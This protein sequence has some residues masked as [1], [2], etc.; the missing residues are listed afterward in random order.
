MLSGSERERRRPWRPPP[1]AASE[2]RARGG[3]GAAGRPAFRGGTHPRG[4]CK[5]SA[6]T[7]VAL[8]L[9]KGNLRAMHP[10][11]AHHSQLH[12][13]LN[14]L[15]GT[16]AQRGQ[17]GVRSVAQQ[18]DAARTPHIL[19]QMKRSRLAAC[20]VA[21]L[22]AARAEP[23]CLGTMDTPLSTAN[24]PT[25]WS[26]LF[27]RTQQAPT[28]LGRRQLP[29]LPARDPVRLYHQRQLV[30]GV[31]VKVQLLCRAGASSA[32]HGLVGEQLEAGW[33]P[34]CGAHKSWLAS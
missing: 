2:R 16:L 31:V 6:G 3:E 28:H 14:G 21:Q 32:T 26:R 20:V 18:R 25:P 30:H 10:P 15:A 8:R 33:Q 24:E 23:T 19:R 4:L 1:G 13:A 29:Q 11:A 5:C 7:T 9:S 22:Q 34:Q 17:H 12:S 27:L